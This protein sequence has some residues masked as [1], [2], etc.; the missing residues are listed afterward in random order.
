MWWGIRDFDGLKVLVLSEL[1]IEIQ[2]IIL[3]NVVRHRRMLSETIFVSKV[4]DQCR[5]S[6]KLS[7]LLRASLELV[8]RDLW[9]AVL[10]I[11]GQHDLYIY[12]A[13]ELLK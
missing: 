7:L 10:L 8:D 6:L 12:L 11:G 5:S 13:P 9:Y 4:S 1:V 2:W 3:K